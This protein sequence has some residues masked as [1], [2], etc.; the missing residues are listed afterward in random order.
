MTH[1]TFKPAPQASTVQ[2][3]AQLRW[4]RVGVRPVVIVALLLAR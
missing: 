2:D 1:S 4:P 3:A